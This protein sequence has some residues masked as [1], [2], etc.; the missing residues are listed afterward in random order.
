MRNRILVLSLQLF[1][2]SAC[3][4]YAE[5]YSTDGHLVMLP[6]HAQRAQELREQGKFKQAIGEYQKHIEKRLSDE[7]RPADENPY[8]YYLLIGDTYREMDDFAEAKLAY[9]TAQTHRVDEELVK[10][11]FRLLGKYWEDKHEYEKAIEIL[12]VYRELDPEMFN[13]DIDRIHKRMIREEEEA[14]Q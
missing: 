13:A 4:F 7:S 12:M 5:T 6:S 2:L 1:F 10:D 3:Y 8:F 9:E 11:R 14:K